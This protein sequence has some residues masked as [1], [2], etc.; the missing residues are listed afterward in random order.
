MYQNPRFAA[1][2]SGC[3][4][5]AVRILVGN[6]FHLTPRER[7]EDLPVLVRSDIPL[8]FV[9]TLSLEILGDKPLIIHLEIILDILQGGRVI[10]DH[11]VGI[12][13]H[14]VDLLDFLP[15]ELIQ[16]CIVFNF[17]SELVVLY[18]SDIHSIIQ[19]QETAF[20]L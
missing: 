18:S 2:R 13:S 14:Y 19:D 8:D 17:V 3:N 10:L 6:D 11:K 7:S 12:F 1:S 15:I 9:S 16:L 4:N 20:Q 5:Y